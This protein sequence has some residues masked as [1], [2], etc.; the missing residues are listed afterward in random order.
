MPT[1]LITGANR[2]IGLEFARE[3]AEGGWEVI[4]TAVNRTRSWMSWASESN[5]SIFPIQ[6]PSH[7]LP[8]GSTDHSTSSYRTPAP[9]TP[10]TPEA[11]RTHGT[12]R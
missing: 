4:A 9:I 10:W 11:R 1:V 12:G 7:P 3:Y 5:R 6:M 8:A 2:G